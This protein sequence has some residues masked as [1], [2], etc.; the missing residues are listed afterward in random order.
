MSGAPSINPPTSLKVVSF[1]V[2]AQS[3]A[4]SDMHSHVTKGTLKA[5][6]RI[7][8]LIEEVLRYGDVDVINCQEVDMMDELLPA[9]AA[10]GYSLAAYQR[11][12][13][14]KQDGC[15]TFFRPSTVDIVA[16]NTVKF[17]LNLHDGVGTLVRMQIKS[18]VDARPIIVA[19]THLYWKPRHEGI[20]WVP[21]P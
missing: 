11:K 15:A 16:A 14:G 20:T 12:T 8:Q 9:L 13:S 4:R 17:G 2:L 5:K 10:A 3:L 1:N 6:R 19:N 18:D 7:P 21:Q